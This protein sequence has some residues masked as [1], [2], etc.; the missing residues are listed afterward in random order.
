MDYITSRCRVEDKGY[1]S[2]CWIWQRSMNGYGYGIGCINGKPEGAHRISYRLHTGNTIERW[3]DIDH[4]CTNTTC[5]NPTHLEKV[6]YLENIRRRKSNKM[7]MQK[8]RELRR[9][10]NEEG[11]N[12]HQLAERFGISAGHAQGI[13]HGYCWIEGCEA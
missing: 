3:E 8:A 6:T 11:L 12:K 13:L 7:T 10:H 9:L 2:P 5:V 4:L 1:D